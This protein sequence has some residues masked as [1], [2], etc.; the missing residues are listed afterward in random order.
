ML[1]IKNKEDKSKQSSIKPLRFQ[2]K[3]QEVIIFT[4]T[5]PSLLNFC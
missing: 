5:M 4:K 1:N 3:R 2:L